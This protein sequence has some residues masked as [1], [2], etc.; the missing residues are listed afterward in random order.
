MIESLHSPHIVRVK[1][2]ISSKGAKERRESARYVAEGVQFVREAIKAK[3]I[4]QVDVLYLTANGRSRLENDKIDLAKF[5]C[6]DVTDAVMKAMS[7]TISPQGILAICKIPNPQLES[8][9]LS[10]KSILLYLHEIQDPGNAGTILRSADALGATAVITSPGSVDMY[11]PKVVRST[12]GSLWHLPIFERVSLDLLQTKIPNL[13][14]ATLSADGKKS[15]RNFSING[16]T[17]LIFGN[18]ARGL[19]DLEVPAATQAL[20]IPMAGNAESLN[21]SAAVSIVLYELTAKI[22]DDK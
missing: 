20:A 12:A 21:L 9:K 4:D 7:E 6:E 3:A 13:N 17:V 10:G 18:E 15:I 16:N 14:F 2:L 11:S 19:A 22:A 5:K 8:L 1:A